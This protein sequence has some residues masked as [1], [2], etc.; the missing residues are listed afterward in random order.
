MVYLVEYESFVHNYSIDTQSSEVEEP[1]VALVVEWLEE[2]D[3]EYQ[4]H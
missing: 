1:L 4:K 3:V 2:Y